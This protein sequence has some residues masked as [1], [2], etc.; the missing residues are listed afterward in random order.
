MIYTKIIIGYNYTM[1]RFFFKFPHQ[2]IRE[3]KI[4][5]QEREGK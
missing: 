1:S 2:P 3:E 4:D 5:Q